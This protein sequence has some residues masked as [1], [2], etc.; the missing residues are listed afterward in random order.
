MTATKKVLG[1][2]GRKIL[3]N[4]WA[5][6]W[7]HADA[8]VVHHEFH[9]P[10]MKEPF[11]E[12]LT[13]GAD[14]F[15]ERRADQW[16]SDD[17]ANTALHPDDSKWAI[18][19]W[20]PRVVKAG[21]KYWAIVMPDAALGKLSLKRIIVLYRDLGVDVDVFGTPDEALAGLKSR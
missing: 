6:L 16:L 19:E 4:K 2:T 9:Q 18:E 20:S 3:E 13:K 1:H 11:R 17:R 12:V 21:W 15:E 10:I 8:K 5:T 7:Y 14:L